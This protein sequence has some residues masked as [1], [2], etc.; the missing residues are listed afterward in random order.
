MFFLSREP[1]VVKE[2]ANKCDLPQLPSFRLQEIIKITM[3][4]LFTKGEKPGTYTSIT[5]LWGKWLRNLGHVHKYGLISE[6]Q[7]SFTR[8]THVQQIWLKIL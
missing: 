1:Q 7:Y 4:L 8:M 6:R 5:Q 2:P 3:S